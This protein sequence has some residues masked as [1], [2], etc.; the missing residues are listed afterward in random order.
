M[1]VST[2]TI[3]NDDTAAWETKCSRGQFET[4]VGEPWFHGLLALARLMNSLRYVQLC[5]ISE[6]LSVTAGMRQ[7]INSFLFM[8]S[9]LFEGYKLIQAL[10][11]DH[12][13]A[14]EWQSGFGAMLKGGD[15]AILV[16]DHL[17]R[18]RDK[19]VFHVDAQELANRAR[20]H[21]AEDIVFVRGI[22]RKAGNTYYDLSDMLAMRSFVGTTESDDAFMTDAADLM[23]RTR[24]LATRFLDAGDRLLTRVL[25][26]HGF[27][28]ERLATG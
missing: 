9:L 5:L 7:R 12:R 19:V 6:E 10:A 2:E 8:N 18:A 4:F 20:E 13:A 21:L 14:A 11:R 28:L 24:D 17:K 26:D 1:R 27:T 15:F 16:S 23:E 3:P 22:G 25:V